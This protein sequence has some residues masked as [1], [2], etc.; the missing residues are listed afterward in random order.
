MK[1]LYR[2]KGQKGKGKRGKE[3]TIDDWG[4]GIGLIGLMGRIG[5]KE[6]FEF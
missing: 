4:L 2:E 6:S 5:R 1:E 3:L